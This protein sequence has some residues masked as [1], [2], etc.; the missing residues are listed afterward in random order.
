VYAKLFSSILLSSVWDQSHEAVRVWITLLALADSEGVVYGTIGGVA[1]AARVDK[2]KAAEAIE[3]F[4]APDAESSSSDFEGRRL[5]RVEGGWR[6]LNY[7]RYRKTRDAEARRSANAEAKRRERERARS[8]PLLT[9]S[10]VSP[11]EEIR[12]DQRR[13]DTEEIHPSAPLREDA[14][15]RVKMSDYP[16]FRSL[17]ENDQISFAT[18]VTVRFRSLHLA[19]FSIEPRM[20]GKDAPTFPSILEGTAKAR[21][22]DPLELLDATFKLWASRDRDKIARG[23]P[24]AAFCARFG[25]LVGAAQQDDGSSA[26]DRLLEEISKARREDRFSDMDRLDREWAKR[27]GGKK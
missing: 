18:R 20:G 21:G 3:T 15:A 27:F 1:S 2:A 8:A 10:D 16:A 26:S 23:S 12:S 13:G 6:V 17:P 11:S 9:V 5:E 25:E 22:V 14:L 19:A 7:L 4:L 24:Y